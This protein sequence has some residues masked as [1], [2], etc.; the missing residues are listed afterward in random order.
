MSYWDF[1]GG[2]MTTTHDEAFS[3]PVSTQVLYL[4]ARF[5]TSTTDQY[6]VGEI[7]AARTYN[8]ALSAGEVAQNYESERRF[9][10]K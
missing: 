2:Y 5:R 10:G 1:R 9:Y 3:D 6:L 4:G 7:G 8:R